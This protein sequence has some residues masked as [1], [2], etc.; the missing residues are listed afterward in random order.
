MYRIGKYNSKIKFNMLCRYQIF[1]LITLTLMVTLQMA[2]LPGVAAGG[3]TS[4]S[5]ANLA[6]TGKKIIFKFYFLLKFKTN[7]NLL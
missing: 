7:N 3:S 6:N 4:S 5:S 2:P 1:F